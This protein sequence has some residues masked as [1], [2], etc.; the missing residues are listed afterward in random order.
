MPGHLSRDCQEPRPNSGPRDKQMRSEGGANTNPGAII[1][2]E[3]VAGGST[4]Y[5][6]AEQ[7]HISRDCP[8]SSRGGG[9]IGGG[10]SRQTSICICHAE[11]RPVELVLQLR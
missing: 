2:W 8:I 3:Y 7:G 9:R 1:G 5:N 10:E 6:C 11:F 4:C